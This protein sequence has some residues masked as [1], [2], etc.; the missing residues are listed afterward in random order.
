MEKI[1]YIREIIKNDHDIWG[2]QNELDSIILRMFYGFHD[3]ALP[4]ALLIKKL[5]NQR[6][7]CTSII[8]NIVVSN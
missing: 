6:T 2:S 8:I 7:K 3:Y 5:G 1:R 4:K